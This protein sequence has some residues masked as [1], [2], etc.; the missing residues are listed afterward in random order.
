[1]SDNAPKIPTRE[2]F[3]PAALGRLDEALD[4]VR[5]DQIEE[6]AAIR[7]AIKN[8]NGAE[9]AD[10]WMSKAHIN[11]ILELGQKFRP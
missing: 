7:Q 10:R 5:Q 8:G 3:L 2:E 11:T 9:F 4:D 1:M 6:N